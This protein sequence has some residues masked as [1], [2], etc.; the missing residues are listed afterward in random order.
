MAI[1]GIG[2]WF[3]AEAIGRVAKSTLLNGSSSPE[4]KV[5]L[6]ALKGTNQAV[7]R[8]RV[9]RCLLAVGSDEEEIVGEGKSG[10]ERERG[11]TG[12]SS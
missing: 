11:G 8:A 10:E 9:N 3:V 1:L 6:L 4:T 7:E 2:A 12:K 5:A